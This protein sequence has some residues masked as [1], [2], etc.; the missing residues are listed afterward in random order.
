[1]HVKGTLSKKKQKKTKFDMKTTKK[2]GLDSSTG[3]IMKRKM[4]QEIWNGTCQFLVMQRDK[5]VKVKT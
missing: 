3:T 4:I 5:S 2:N 1:M